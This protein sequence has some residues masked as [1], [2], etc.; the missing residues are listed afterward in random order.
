MAK[1]FHEKNADGE[2]TNKYAYLYS[3][4]AGNLTK[5]KH[6][7]RHM[8]DWDLT[9][10]FVIPALIDPSALSV[11]DHWGDRKTTG[12]NLLKNWGNVETTR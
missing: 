10:P 9:G 2:V 7:K 11:E 12:V 3:K 1:H 8:D 5:I 6:F 4:Y